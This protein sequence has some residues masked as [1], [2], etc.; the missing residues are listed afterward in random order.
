M[1][2]PAPFP[3]IEIA[4]KELIERD[5]DAEGKVGGD[6]SYDPSTDFY[7]WIGLVP[8][9]A[10]NVL[11]GTWVVDIDVFSKGYGTSMDKSLALE[12]LLLKPGGH[13][14]TVMRIDSVFENI[15]P[16][17]RPWDDDA[18]FRVGGTYAF[19]ARRSG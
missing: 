19:A 2:T 16:T 5:L 15:G 10:S 18:V 4:L 14:T 11:E 9:G 8:G 12:A 7:I 13:R 17:E 3:M 1:T 6:L